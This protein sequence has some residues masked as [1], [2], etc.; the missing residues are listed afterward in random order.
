LEKE[1]L[2]DVDGRLTP[3]EKNQVRAEQYRAQE[4]EALLDRIAVLEER[5]AEMEKIS[6][7]AAASSTAGGLTERMERDRIAQELLDE[8]PGVTRQIVPSTWS[9][10]SLNW[11][12]GN[13][14]LYVPVYLAT[15]CLEGAEPSVEGF[16]EMVTAGVVTSYEGKLRWDLPD[17]VNHVIQTINGK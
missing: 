8:V 9:G 3:A 10:A 1:G 11:A 7:A 15:A 4:E 13:L 5:I 6:P 12:E 2:R 17:R 14:A 16:K